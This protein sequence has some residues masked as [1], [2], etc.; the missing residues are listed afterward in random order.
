MAKSVLS[1]AKFQSSGTRS[2]RNR[3]FKEILNKIGPNIDPTLSEREFNVNF[4][5]ENYKQEYFVNLK[6]FKKMWRLVVR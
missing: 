4:K 6:I 2:E 3:S 5:F 1:S